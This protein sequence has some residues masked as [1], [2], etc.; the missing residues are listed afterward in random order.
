MTR[1]KK[2]ADLKKKCISFLKLISGIP[3]KQANLSRI[4]RAYNLLRHE[5][6]SQPLT[7]F[8]N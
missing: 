8:T 2:E 3:F 1:D 5:N 7:L 4:L 6:F